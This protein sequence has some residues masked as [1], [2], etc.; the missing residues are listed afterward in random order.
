MIRGRRH[1]YLCLYFFAPKNYFL[2]THLNQYRC[3]VAYLFV[4]ALELHV[5]ALEPL[6]FLV[7][8][9]HERLRCN[10]LSHYF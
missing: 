1:N 2:A 10:F 8:F 3:K 9:E 7:A 4:V 5:L 6:E